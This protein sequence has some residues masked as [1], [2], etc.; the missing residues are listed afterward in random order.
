MCGGINLILF[1]LKK[2]ITALFCVAFEENVLCR[3][4]FVCYVCAYAIPVAAQLEGRA[5]GFDTVPRDSGQCRRL[6]WRPTAQRR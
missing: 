1:G 5:L 2:H 4:T 3:V 6:T